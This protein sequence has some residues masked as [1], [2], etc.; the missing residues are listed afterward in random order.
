MHAAP[1]PSL[2]VA[3]IGGGLAAAIA[4]GCRQVASEA[5]VDAA[6][7]ASPDPAAE[8]P[9]CDAG[10]RF[11]DY[12]WVPDDARLTASIQRDDPQLADALATLARMTEAPEVT[13]PVFAALDFRNLALQLDNLD[14]VLDELGDDPGE[15]VELHSPAGETVWLW[16]SACPPELLAAR[17][18]GRWQIMLRAD[19]E[20]PGGRFGAG[21]PD[22]FPFDVLTIA[23]L[24]ERRVALTRV[25]Q[26]AKV[27]AWLRESARGGEHGPAH[28]LAEIDAAPLRCVLD[29]SSLLTPSAA[30]TLDPPHLRVRVTGRSWDTSASPHTPE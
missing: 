28:A 25:G 2:A 6:A 14:R 22:G 3:L 20:H 8:S 26:G 9:A 23:T 12:D 19:P 5:P 24:D 13:L 15:L 10:L 30:S 27:G 1:K 16:P 4:L 17:V 21:S 29:G 18:L 11:A 7:T